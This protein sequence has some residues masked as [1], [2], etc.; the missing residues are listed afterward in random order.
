M[1]YTNLAGLLIGIGVFVIA[2]KIVFKS[3]WSE[4]FMISL[5][6]GNT[7]IWAGIGLIVIGFVIMLITKKKKDEIP[8][9]N[10]H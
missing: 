9:K 5:V 4:A 1:R 3:I 10:R 6:G 2:F 8:K 7:I